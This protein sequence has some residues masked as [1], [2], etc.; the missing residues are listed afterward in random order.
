MNPSLFQEG[1][2]LWGSAQ[3]P[4]VTVFSK[5]DGQEFLAVKADKICSIEDIPESW[6]GLR[7]DYMNSTSAG[8]DEYFREPT[9]LNDPV[10]RA[11]MYDIPEL[12]EGMTLF[13]ETNGWNWKISF[14]DRKFN[15]A[16]LFL[17]KVNRG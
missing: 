14:I 10:R 2:Q 8:P 4:R 3:T 15:L 16:I 1:D 13:D 7:F 6:T 17:D 12:T 5:I 9:S 11:I